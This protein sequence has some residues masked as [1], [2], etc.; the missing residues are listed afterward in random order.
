MFLD[1]NSHSFAGIGGRIFFKNIY[2]FILRMDV[3][4]SLNDNRRG[5]VM[6]L[7]HYF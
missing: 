2:D 1:A 6:G 3:G 7:G 4:F 5:F